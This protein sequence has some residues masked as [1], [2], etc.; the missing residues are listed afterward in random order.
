MSLLFLRLALGWMYLYAGVSKITDSAWSA[1]GY[2]KGAKTFSS[3][4]LWLASPGVLPVVNLLNEWGLALL[5]ASL[6]LGLFVRQS[7]LLGILLMTLYYLPILRFPYVGSH[8]FLVDEHIVFIGALCVLIAG[9]AGRI[10][11]MDAM[12]KNS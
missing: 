4:Y 10:W 2:L 8:F 9:R 7:A 3:L 6:I 12:R 11:G 1:E 5:G